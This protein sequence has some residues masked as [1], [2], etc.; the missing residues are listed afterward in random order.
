LLLDII[1]ALVAVKSMQAIK[2]GHVPAM[3]LVTNSSQG[4]GNAEQATTSLP[5]LGAE[6]TAAEG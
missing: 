4:R 1:M 2:A 6:A 3:G 5:R